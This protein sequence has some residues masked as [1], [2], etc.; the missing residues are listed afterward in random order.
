MFEVNYQDIIGEPPKFSG[1]PS[2][3]QQEEAKIINKLK[4]KLQQKL[5]LYVDGK[6]LTRLWKSD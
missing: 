4:T 1:N 6:V 3:G 2:E 5:Q